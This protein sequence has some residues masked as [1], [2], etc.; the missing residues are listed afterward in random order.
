LGNLK[1]G[2]FTRNFD[3]KRALCKWSVSLYES[4]VRRIWREG[5]FTRNY[6][7]YVRHVKEGY[8][9]A[10]SLSLLRL[11]DGNLERELLN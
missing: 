6:A 11:C 3:S 2:S 4:S 10:A 5:S 8:C 7:S 1:V 9:H